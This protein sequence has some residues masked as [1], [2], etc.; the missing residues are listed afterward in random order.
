VSHNH[1]VLNL[2]DI[3]RV[4]N[5]GQTVEI[6][7]IDNVGDVSMNEHLA[8]PQTQDL[9]GWHTAVRATDPKIPR[10]LN[11]HQFPEKIRLPARHVLC[12]SS[13]GF[14]KT[15]KAHATALANPV[16]KCAGI[17]PTRPR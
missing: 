15:F 4:L 2:Q 1:D 16:P 7:M 3:Y 17:P 5:D 11:I 10:R 14:E 9:I 13:V 6:R 12:P 8:G